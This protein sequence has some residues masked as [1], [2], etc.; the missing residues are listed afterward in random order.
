MFPYPLI[1]TGHVLCLGTRIKR[2]GSDLL[3]LKWPAASTFTE[4]G[5]RHCVQ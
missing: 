5:P 4:V 2:G 3:G 1:W